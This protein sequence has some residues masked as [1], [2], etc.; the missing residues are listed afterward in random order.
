MNAKTRMVVVWAV[1]W[2]TAILTWFVYSGG[3]MMVSYHVALSVLGI[4]SACLAFWILK[5]NRTW[6]SVILVVLGLVVGQ[7][8]LVEMSIMYVLWSVRGFAP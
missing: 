7:W 5:T 6:R 8:W 2:L 1:F 3:W 4:I